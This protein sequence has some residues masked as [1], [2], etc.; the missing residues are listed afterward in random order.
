MNEFFQLNLKL[1]LSLWDDYY[2]ISLSIQNVDI[3]IFHSFE[4]NLLAR[5][6]NLNIYTKS[7]RFFLSRKNIR[8]STQKIYL[9]YSK[10]NPFTKNYV[11][12]NIEG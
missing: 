8:F 12:G 1:K 11:S 4:S 5:A 9:L 10:M 3:L 7:I 6:I 2:L